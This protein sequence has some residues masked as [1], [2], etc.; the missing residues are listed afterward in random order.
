VYVMIVEVALGDATPEQVE[1]ELGKAGG[2]AGVEV[3]IRE[4]GGDAL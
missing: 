2:E 4:L 3:S 1:A